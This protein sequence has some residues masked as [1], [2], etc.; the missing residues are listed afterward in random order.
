M[1]LGSTK[2][3]VDSKLYFK[4]E[5]KRPMMLLLNDL[6]LIGK[7]ELIRYARRRLTAEFEI[8][9][10]HMMHYFLVMEVWKNADGISLNKGSM[11]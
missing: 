3:K 6:F 11:Q 9:E 10:L 7:E 4:V 5:G 8:K 2:S 1:G